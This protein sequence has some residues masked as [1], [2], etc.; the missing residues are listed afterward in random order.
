M[1]GVLASVGGFDFQKNLTKGGW[2]LMTFSIFVGICSVVSSVIAVLTFVLH[3][4]DRKRKWAVSGTDSSL[5]WSKYF[6][7]LIC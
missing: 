7:L 3:I 1:G 6:V 5:T 4:Y 2:Y